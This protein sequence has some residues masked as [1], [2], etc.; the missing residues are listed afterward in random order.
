ME[1]FPLSW[2]ALRPGP[3]NSSPPPL[4]PVTQQSY[5]PFFTAA[6]VVVPLIWKLKNT[7]TA[8]HQNKNSGRCAPRYNLMLTCNDLVNY[9]LSIGSCFD[10]LITIF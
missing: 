9:S 2:F 3:G 4:P 1:T 6:L 5:Y 8:H 7:H 10:N